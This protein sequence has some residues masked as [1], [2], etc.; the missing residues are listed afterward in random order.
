MFEDY[1]EDYLP[2]SV[3]DNMDFSEAINNLINEEVNKRYREK[4][5]NYDEA[6]KK[7]SELRVENTVQKG[8]RQRAENDLDEAV[9]KAKLEGA[10]QQKTEMLGEYSIGETVWV[11]RFCRKNVKCKRCSGTDKVIAL[12][13]GREVQVRCRE[14]K[15]SGY[16][17]EEWYEPEEGIVEE[18]VIYV[19]HRGSKHQVYVRPANSNEDAI[20]REN[21][22]K[23]KEECQSHIENEMNKEK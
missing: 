23:T 21:I 13:D 12:L 3:S 6:L 14:C 20:R 18:I 1:W 2:D 7:A 5:K 9:K 19:K 17:V 22:F 16:D 11:P 15:F 10:E 4:N 8:L